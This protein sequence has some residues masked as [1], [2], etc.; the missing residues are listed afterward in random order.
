MMAPGAWKDS[1][2]VLQTLPL[3]FNR[4]LQALFLYC[5]LSFSGTGTMSTIPGTIP[6]NAGIM[7]QITCTT[8]IMHIFRT[9]RHRDYCIFAQNFLSQYDCLSFL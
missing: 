3:L 2:E 4:F 5:F 6:Y 9:D 1:K 7:H 8:H